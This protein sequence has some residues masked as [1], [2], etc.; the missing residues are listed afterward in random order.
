M[1]NISLFVFDVNQKLTLIKNIFPINISRNSKLKF[2][3]LNMSINI[4]MRD[5]FLKKML[6]GQL[7]LFK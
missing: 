2:D 6:N 3:I 7:R 5:C 4:Q 1:L